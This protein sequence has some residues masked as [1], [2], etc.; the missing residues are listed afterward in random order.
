MKKNPPCENFGSLRHAA[1]CF[2]TP[3]CSSKKKVPQHAAACCGCTSLT[4][5][6]PSAHAGWPF[7]DGGYRQS[8]GRSAWK[9]FAALGILGTAA[10]WCCISRAT[11]LRRVGLRH[12]SGGAGW[13]HDEVVVEAWG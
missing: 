12:S 6:M 2:K 3:M 5:H 11:P 4:Q 9:S 7:I 1:A 8:N 13:Q 10:Q